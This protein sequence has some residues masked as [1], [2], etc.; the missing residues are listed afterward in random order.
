MAVSLA[1]LVVGPIEINAGYVSAGLK[2]REYKREPRVW[3]LHTQT[4]LV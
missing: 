3:F 1:E 2:S 4:W